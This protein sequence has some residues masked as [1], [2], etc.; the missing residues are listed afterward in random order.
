MLYTCSKS[1]SHYSDGGCD[2]GTCGMYLILH[3][4]PL[5]IGWLPAIGATFLILRNSFSAIIWGI[6]VG[7]ISLIICTLFAGLYGNDK[8]EELKTPFQIGIA[9]NFLLIVSG[10]LLA[11]NNSRKV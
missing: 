5:L 9:I 11:L 6:V 4:I 7:F 3:T 1:S 8:I 10:I 2:G